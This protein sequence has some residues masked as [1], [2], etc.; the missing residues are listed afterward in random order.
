MLGAMP[1][2]VLPLCCHSPKLPAHLSVDSFMRGRHSRFLI[3]AIVES[4]T[5][6]DRAKFVVLVKSS[7]GSARNAKAAIRS[8][9]W[10]RIGAVNVINAYCLCVLG[11]RKNGVNYGN[12]KLVVPAMTLANRS[13]SWSTMSLIPI[14]ASMEAAI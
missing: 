8:P 3:R 7:R 5:M 13:G 14:A 2:A 11:S 6:D 4:G 1:V 10:F 12:P 9:A